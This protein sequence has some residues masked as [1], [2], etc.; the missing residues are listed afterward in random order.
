MEHDIETHIN[1]Y[2]RFMSKDLE[3]AFNADNKSKGK[4]AIKQEDSASVHK[5]SHQPLSNLVPSVSNYEKKLDKKKF[6]K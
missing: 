1:S 3:S 5:S 2:A 4:I 6:P